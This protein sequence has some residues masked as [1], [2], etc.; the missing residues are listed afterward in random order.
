MAEMKSLF[1]RC[2]EIDCTSIIRKNYA[3]IQYISWADAWAML[4]RHFPDA[5]YGI[6]YFDEKPYL[7]T[8]LG[9]FVSI[10]VC[11]EDQI[12]TEVLPVMDNKMNAIELPDAREIN[13]NLKRCLVK[14]IA[15]HGLGLSVY[16]S[17]DVYAKP[18]A[19]KAVQK[20]QANLPAS[21]RVIQI[22]KHKGATFEEQ[23]PEQIKNFMNWIYDNAKEQEIWAK[24]FLSDATDYLNEIGQK[25]S[26][27]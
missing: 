12:M 16:E 8:E 3:G 27:E 2:Y 26:N 13:D 15:L 23:G 17:D 21:Q 1:E 9:V 19:P 5:T 6:R 20:S 18:S 4:K 24:A 10:F 14:A 7:K 22:G 25:A 11:I